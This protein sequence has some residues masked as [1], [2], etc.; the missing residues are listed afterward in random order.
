MSKTKLTFVPNNDDKGDLIEEHYIHP[1]FD[2]RSASMPFAE[3]E[4]AL[5]TKGDTKAVTVLDLEGNPQPVQ[6][7]IVSLDSPTREFVDETDALGEI[8]ADE[9]E[10]V[11]D[12]DPSFRENKL[13]VIASEDGNAPARL[14][15][16]E[17]DV[18]CPE[19]ED[20][21]GE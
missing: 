4:A 1:G 12:P 21:P 6:M 7:D 17:E 9:I 11:S 14:I 18:E 13:A 20:I 16:T 2:D 10:S 3:L 5:L 15:E 19:V 8:L